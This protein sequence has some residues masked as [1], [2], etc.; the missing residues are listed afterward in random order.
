[1]NPG[2]ELGEAGDGAQGLGIGPG[3]RQAAP[4]GGVRHPGRQEMMGS[5]IGRGK[6]V[7]KPT[8]VYKMIPT[9]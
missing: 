9:L 2:G 5:P 4:A 8:S 1:M 6:K 3:R 7:R